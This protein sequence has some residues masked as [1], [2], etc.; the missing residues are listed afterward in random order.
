MGR[1]PHEVLLHAF[2]QGPLSVAPFGIGGE[3]ESPPRGSEL[4]DLAPQPIDG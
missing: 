1:E 3:R 4:L 2:V